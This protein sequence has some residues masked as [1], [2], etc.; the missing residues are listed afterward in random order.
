[1]DAYYE[2]MRDDMTK[3]KAWRVANDHF[4]PHFHHSIEL[5]YVVSGLL[6]ATL[7]GVEYAAGPGTVVLSGSYTVHNYHTPEASESIVAIIPLAVVPSLRPVLSKQSFAKP[8]YA[9]ADGTLGLLMGMMTEAMESPITMKG[10]CYTALGLLM[11]RVGMVETRVSSRMEFIRDVLEYLQ[12]HHT[13]PLSVER[14]SSHF[15]YSRSRFSHIFN[16]QLGYSLTDY[17][18]AIRCRHAAQLLRETDMAVS[19]IALAVGFE[20][21]R[22]FYRSFKEQYGLTPNRYAKATNA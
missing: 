11:D 16:A 7:D 21:L 3:A 13:E 2:T 10:L 17:I 15:G 20:S 4:A 8:V 22:T 19:D 5:A 12:Q 6:M 18:G 1:M 9:D 14:V